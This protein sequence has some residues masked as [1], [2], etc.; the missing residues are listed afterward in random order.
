MPC[1]SG[2]A[3]ART[4]APLLSKE[5]ITEL[6]PPF[7]AARSVPKADAIFPIATIVLAFLPV[8]REELMT[9]GCPLISDRY[10]PRSLAAY[11]T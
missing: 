4:L 11:W 8:L 10:A 7:A 3:T 5:R 1:G 9:G 6:S 2:P